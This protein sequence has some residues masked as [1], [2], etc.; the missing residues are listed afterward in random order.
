MGY[1]PAAV[2]AAAGGVGAYDT[3]FVEPSAHA[4]FTATGVWPDRTLFVL[5]I[6]TSEHTGSIVTTGHYQTDIL[7]IEAELK[8]ARIP[9]GWGYFAFDADANGPLGATKALPHEAGCFGCHATNGAVE[10]TFTQF[11]PTLLPIARAKGT[12]RRDFPGIPPSVVEI[13]GRIVANGFA[14]ARTAIDEA[15]VKW[16][17]ASVAREVSLNRLGYQLVREK[18]IDDALAVFT[19]VTKRFPDSANAWDSLAETL[20]GAGKLAEARAATDHGL[21]ELGKMPAGG[22]RDGIEKAL[23]ERAERL[24]P[25]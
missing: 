23:R 22:R 16:P 12:V 10:H 2:A 8:D 11:Y 15:A 6:R 24:A 9:G 3:V 5:E 17:E 25:K 19:D 14:A 20:E 21:A 13:H 18:R 1:G 4:A 7:A